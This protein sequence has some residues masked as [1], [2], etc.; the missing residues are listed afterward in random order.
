M[1]VVWFYNLI[2]MLII[3]F[4]AFRLVSAWKY[5]TE[6]ALRG[7]GNVVC[8]FLLAACL[9]SGPMPP[10]L[11]ALLAL[12]SFLVIVVLDIGLLKI[13]VDYATDNR[14]KNAERAKRAKLV[15]ME[16]SVAA[17]LVVLASVF[18]QT[19]TPIGH[20]IFLL[21]AFGTYL[22]WDNTC[23]HDMGKGLL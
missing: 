13:V 1:L 4:A 18:T 16:I 19:V 14:M 5:T 12:F 22:L 8:P 10:A 3:G 20:F 7:L 23:H 17:F 9:S 6:N 21:Y 2:I 11:V 15:L